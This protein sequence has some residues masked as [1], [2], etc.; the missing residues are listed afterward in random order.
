MI[1]NDIAQTSRS[2]VERP[3][4]VHAELRGERD[5]NARDVVAIPDGLDKEGRETKVENVH[6]R[7]LPQ[8]VIDPEDGVLGEHRARH[9]VELARRGEIAP[10][11]FFYDDAR[12]LREPRVAESLNHLLEEGGRNREVVCRST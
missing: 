1:L 8:I 9:R 7:L 2:L 6:D 5:L 4:P 10:E 11:R 12:T 3:A